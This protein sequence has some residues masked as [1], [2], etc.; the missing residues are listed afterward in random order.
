MAVISF[1][2][3][4]SEPADFPLSSDRN[5]AKSAIAAIFAVST[6][7]QNTNIAD[8][9]SKAR[10]VLEGAKNPERKQVVVLL[11]DGVPTLPA[12]KGVP[13]YPQIA[14]QDETG[15]LRSEGVVIFTIGLGDKINKDFMRSIS[16]SSTA[17]FEAPGTTALHSIYSSI[18]TETCVKKPVQVDIIPRVT[19]VTGL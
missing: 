11:T 10:S 19:E 13:E 18:A 3:A 1:A 5:S 6:S 17:Y 15:K 9:L 7:S 8:A 12:K 2:S 16:A 14:A 4:V